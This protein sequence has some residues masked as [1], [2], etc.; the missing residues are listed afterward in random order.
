MAI[1]KEVEP[2]DIKA[3][4]KLLEEI[5]D[6][7][8]GDLYAEHDAKNFCEYLQQSGITFTPEFKKMEKSWRLDESNH[9]QGFCQI[10]SLLYHKSIEEIER[11]L[12]AYQPDFLSIQQFLQDEFSICVVLAYDE[13]AT[14]K[15]YC[16]DFELYPLFVTFGTLKSG[17]FGE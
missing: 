7:I 2:Q 4:D 9:Y 15:A 8:L 14:T 5:H 17:T 1:L 3:T 11:K 12:A 6:T 13:L 10:Y 16:Q